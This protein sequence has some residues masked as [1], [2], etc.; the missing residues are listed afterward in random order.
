MKVFWR[1]KPL[2]QVDID[3]VNLVTEAHNKSTFRENPSTIAVQCAA[4][5]S[6]RLVNSVIAALST[7]GTT[8]GPIEGSY[9][10]IADDQIPAVIVVQGF[11]QSNNKIPGWG[12]SF[13]KTE[14]DPF[15]QPVNDHLRENYQPIYQRILEVTEALLN[16]GKPLLPN[17]SAFTAGAAIALHMPRRLSPYLMITAR[18]PAWA[19]VFLNETKGQ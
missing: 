11:L 19:Q 12:S 14:L 15:W 13:S 4:Q 7:L 6:G 10:V 8:H 3:L 17:P 1:D 2:T 16:A 18:L 9:Q 5:G